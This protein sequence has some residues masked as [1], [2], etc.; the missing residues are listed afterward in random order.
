M[1]SLELNPW[2]TNLACFVGR[3]C[4]GPFN[5]SA[6]LPVLPPAVC[7]PGAG[8]DYLTAECPT[9]VIMAAPDAEQGAAAHPCSIWAT[10]A[11]QVAGLVNGSCRT[12][13]TLMRDP[14]VPLL[15]DSVDA[16]IFRETYYL[17][18]R[19]NQFLSCT[20]SPLEL[21]DKGTRFLFSL[22]SKPTSLPLSPHCIS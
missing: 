13:R 22:F 11:Q 9:D 10:K 16:S 2:E 4:P 18:S 12:W 17:P 19:V 21:M 5:S 7:V 6:E 20:P 8:S 1:V 3:P 15:T 14:S